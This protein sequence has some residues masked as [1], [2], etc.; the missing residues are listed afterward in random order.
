MKNQCCGW[1]ITVFAIALAFS[2][3]TTA[4]TAPL[5]LVGRIPL[6][7]LHDGDFDHFGKD[8]SGKRLFLT[9]G[10]NR[11]VEVFDAKSNKRIHAIKGLKSPHALLYRNDIDRLFGIH[12]DASGISKVIAFS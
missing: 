10:A 8:A 1:V 3:A 5:K 2:T 6:P 4:Q 11:A 12:G 9:A 7:A